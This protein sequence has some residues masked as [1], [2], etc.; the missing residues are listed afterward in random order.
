[1]K[2]KDKGG[3]GVYHF[4]ADSALYVNWSLTNV[5]NYAC[6]YCLPELHNG[7][8]VGVSLDVIKDFVSD[9][10]REFSGTEIFVEL[11]GGEVTSYQHFF[12]LISYLK[13]QDVLVGVISNGSRSKRFWERATPYLDRVYFSYHYEFVDHDRFFSNL[14]FLSRRLPVG[15]NFMMDPRFFDEIVEFFEIVKRETK[16]VE[17]ILQPLY[18]GM[19]GQQYHYDDDQLE[20]IERQFLLNGDN[21]PLKHIKPELCSDRQFRGLM[22]VVS[23]DGTKTISSAQQLI[24]S[25][26]N[27]WKGFACN[28]GI[29]SLV[30]DMTGKIY[31]GW[32]M[33]GGSIGSVVEPKSITYPKL[34]LICGAPKCH[35]AFDVATTKERAID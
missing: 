31:R 11:S 17:C 30:I 28:I 8:S 4:E 6:D 20:R 12:E 2:S 23:S 24:I 29:E 27:H 14:E 22:T 9:L 10:K 26:Q 16:G 3:L 1:M 33:Q 21:F 5:C 25:N 35:C 19:S 15:V 34:P 18:R 13:S 32:C 7:T